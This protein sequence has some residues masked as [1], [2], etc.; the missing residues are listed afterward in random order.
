MRVLGQHGPFSEG[1][2]REGCGV[3]KL[4]LGCVKALSDYIGVV[5]GTNRLRAHKAIAAIVSSK[6]HP[7]EALRPA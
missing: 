1:S 3:D 6:C 7:T 5:L 2:I 4:S